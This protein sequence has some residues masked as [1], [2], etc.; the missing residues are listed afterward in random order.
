MEAVMS[1]S[2]QRTNEDIEQDKVFKWLNANSVAWSEGYG[3]A[4]DTDQEDTITWLKRNGLVI[5]EEDWTDYLKGAG[6]GALAGAGT[7]AVA[8]PYGA[9]AGA[10]L[11]AGLG[12]L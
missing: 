9:L 7:G 5:E 11:G 12:A 4:E 10:L 8:G 1:G 6:G 3:F 2:Y